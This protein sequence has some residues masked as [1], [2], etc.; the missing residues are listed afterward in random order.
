MLAAGGVLGLLLMG[1]AVGGLMAGVETPARGDDDEDPSRDTG[2][3][4]DDAASE[5]APAATWTGDFAG[6]GSLAAD[7]TPDTPGSALALL[8][9]GDT[10]GAD[11]CRAG[12]R[13]GQRVRR[14]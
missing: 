6:D 4:G 8:L 7:D 13:A 11:R 10:S 5:D 9:F 2:P 12:S 3:D 1:A 14:T